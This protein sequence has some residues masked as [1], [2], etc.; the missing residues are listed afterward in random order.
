MKTE[1]IFK[2]QEEGEVRDGVDAQ[3]WP[4]LLPG[5]N[6][7]VEIVTLFEGVIRKDGTVIPI[8]PDEQVSSL[9]LQR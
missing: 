1:D 2:R 7:D 5:H 8:E 6:P 3:Y 9:L 4:W